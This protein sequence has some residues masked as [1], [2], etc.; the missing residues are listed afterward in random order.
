MIQAALAR[1]APVPGQAW[2]ERS[3]RRGLSPAEGAPRG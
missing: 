1:P 2:K 3:S